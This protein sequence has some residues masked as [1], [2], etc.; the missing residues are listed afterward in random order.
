MGTGC[1]DGIAPRGLQCPPCRAQHRERKTQGCS[2]NPRSEWEAQMYFPGFT[3]ERRRGGKDRLPA[4]S[5]I[6]QQGLQVATRGA[7]QGT[8]STRRAGCWPRAKLAAL[9]ASLPQEH[10]LQLCGLS[11]RVSSGGRPK[12]LSALS[13]SQL[14]SL[15][16]PEARSGHPSLPH[17]QPPWGGFQR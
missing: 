3:H 10:P 7:L 1:R 14:G 8:L 11:C 5:H 2:W 16:G 12:A 9:P 15:P 4:G 6:A 17:P 13:G